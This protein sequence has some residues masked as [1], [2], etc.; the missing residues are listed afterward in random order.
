M[1][2]AAGAGA[3]RSMLFGIEPLDALTFVAV[4][5]TVPVVAPAACYVPARGATSIEPLDAL[6]E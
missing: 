4:V 3:L 6:R 2:A 5:I 1:G